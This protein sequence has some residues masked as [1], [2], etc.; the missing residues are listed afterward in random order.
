MT[1]P[2]VLP[3]YTVAPFSGPR[4]H[5]NINR[6]RSIDALPCAIC[7]RAITAA[8]ARIGTWAHVHD[9]GAGWCSDADACPHNPAGDMGMYPV[10]A[11]CDR[12]Y[13]VREATR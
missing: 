8:T 13:R 5:E 1:V 3:T 10:G 9:G 2:H 12:R 7:G 11:D 6:I 4:Y